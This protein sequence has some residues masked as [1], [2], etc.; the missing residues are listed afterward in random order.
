LSLLLNKKNLVAKKKSSI[1]KVRNFAN[2]KKSKIAN[3][4]NESYLILVRNSDQKKQFVKVLLS[5]RVCE[6]LRNKISLILNLFFDLFD[7]RLFFFFSYF[8]FYFSFKITRYVV[9]FLFNLLLIRQIF[10]L[11]YLLLTTILLF[12]ILTTSNFNSNYFN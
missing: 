3:N 4:L 7:N 12:K 5:I 10:K 1:N 8:V 6:R 11:K 2:T 9:T